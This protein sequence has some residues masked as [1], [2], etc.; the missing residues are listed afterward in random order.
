MLSSINL[1]DKDY[2]QF[3]AEAIAQIPLYS[4]EWTN[5]NASEPGITILENLSAF[6]ALQQSEINEVTD[7]I[8]W[9]LLALAGFEPAKG[10]P[11]TAYLQQKAAL[12]DM[13]SGQVEGEKVYAQDICYELPYGH[14]FLNSSIKGIYRVGADKTYDMTQLSEPLGIPGGVLLFGEQPGMEDAL[15]ILIDRLPSYPQEMILYVD[16]KELYQ[17]NPFKEKDENPFAQIQWEILTQEGFQAIQAVD[18]THQFL[19]SG[20]IYITMPQCLEQVTYLEQQQ[21]YVIRASFTKAQYDIPPQI[22]SIQGPLTKVLQ[23]DTRSALFMGNIKNEYE[24][25]HYL[26]EE[27]FLDVYMKEKDG[28]YHLYQDVY[29]TGRENDRTY[30]CIKHGTGHK[31]ITTN[32]TYVDYDAE[33]NIL[34]VCRDLS[35]MPYVSLGRLYGYDEQKLELPPFHQV[36]PD[37]FAVIAAMRKEGD[38]EITYHVVRPDCTDEGEVRYSVSGADNVLII[39]DCGIYEGAEILLGQYVLYQGNEG[40]VLPDTRFVS[41]HCPKACLASCAAGKPGHYEEKI[42]DVRKRFALDIQ[43]P[44][45]IV[46]RTD[47]ENMIRQI[48]GLAIDKMNAVVTGES[49][50]I[51]VVIKPDSPVQYP[52][53]SDLYQKVIYDYLEERRMLTTKIVIEQP[54]YVPVSVYGMIY[55]KKHFTNCREMIEKV[56]SQFLDGTGASH[57]FGETVCFHDI[58]HALESLECV[59]EIYDFKLV[60]GNMA[61]SAVYGL[62]I[63]LA[64]NALYYPGDIAVELGTK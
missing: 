60:S 9:K 44:A 58:Y 31:C 62:D 38:S 8:K 35:V 20:Y 12:Q 25:C 17:R 6:S 30:E 5:L 57:S 39:H 22:R 61:A 55:V 40:N 43:T 19:V 59:D 48:P 16:V 3:M 63:R 32:S 23:Q 10:E 47:C 15:Y 41:P 14:H 64:H 45:T 26:L 49:N 56:I 2:D 42:E 51:H 4:R 34:V 37:Q 46:T 52:E 54:V 36:L 13:E 53:L 11:A 33:N 29:T 28:R 27:G 18:D 50:E 1:N 21:A 24:L 7:K